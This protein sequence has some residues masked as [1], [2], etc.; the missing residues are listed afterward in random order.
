[1]RRGSILDQL[2]K[3]LFKESDTTNIVAM[4]GLGGIGKTQIALELAYQVRARF[5]DCSIF[6]MSATIKESIENAFIGAAR[7]LRIP[8]FENN[9]ANAKELVRDFLSNETAGRWAFGV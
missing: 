2:N 7:A 9:K 4:S 5:K 3:I 8:G 1:M 6:W